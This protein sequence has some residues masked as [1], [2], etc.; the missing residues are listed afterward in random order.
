MSVRILEVL[1]CEPIVVVPLLLPSQNT[2]SV[3]RLPSSSKVGPSFVL[4]TLLFSCKWANIASPEVNPKP[5]LAA[6]GM[7]VLGPFYLSSVHTPT[8]EN[9]IQSKDPIPAVTLCRDSGLLNIYS[10]NLFIS[11]L[12]VQGKPNKAPCLSQLLLIQRFM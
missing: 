11:L 3:S 12:T 5:E 7:S 6:L 4:F 2:P 1:W 10:V 9:N 8:R